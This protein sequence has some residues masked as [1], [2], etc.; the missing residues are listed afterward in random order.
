MRKA[1]R[2]SMMMAMHMCP[3]CMMMRAQNSAL[4]CFTAI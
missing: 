1:R 4:P 3:M 2:N